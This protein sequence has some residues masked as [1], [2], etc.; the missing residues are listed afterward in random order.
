MKPPAQ[1]TDV[2]SGTPRSPPKLSRRT[3]WSP[4]S[5]S[6]KE[7]ES[8]PESKFISFKARFYKEFKGRS[9]TFGFN[10]SDLPNDVQLKKVLLECNNNIDDAVYSWNCRLRR[11][12]REREKEVNKE[13]PNPVHVEQ[14]PPAEPE[15]VT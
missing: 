11:E 13:H 2:P 3:Q 14:S 9:S 5:A 10:L 1:S 8:D 15:K 4:A 12:Q 6:A 7:H